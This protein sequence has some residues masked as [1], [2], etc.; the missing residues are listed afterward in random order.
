MIKMQLC[1]QNKCYIL[2]VT[3]IT[4]YICKDFFLFR[5]DIFIKGIIYMGKL[6]IL[7]TSSLMFNVVSFFSLVS[8][9]HYT[10]NTSSFTWFYLLG[11][12]VAQILLIIYGIV[13]KAPE[14]YIPTSFLFIGLCYIVYKKFIN[15]LDYD[16]TYLD[17][18]TLKI[19][20]TY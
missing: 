15:G 7:A 17:S 1:A 8:N 11:N 6:G 18:V 20:G 5:Y 9:I 16:F 10:H 12:L 19:M 13:N 4:K 3:V 14:I 2:L